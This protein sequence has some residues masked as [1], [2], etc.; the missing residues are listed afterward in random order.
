MKGAETAQAEHEASRI[1]LLVG[2]ILDVLTAAEGHPHVLHGKPAFL[3]LD[4]GVDLEPKPGHDQ[5]RVEDEVGDHLGRL[6]VE[7]WRHMA[8]DAERDGDCGVTEAFLH[9]PRM[10]SALQRQ[11]GPRVAQPLQG[12][13]R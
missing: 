6:V 2:P 7:R 4:H 12:Q 13:P 8:V 5:L 1:R 10:Y 11:R 9:D 3:H